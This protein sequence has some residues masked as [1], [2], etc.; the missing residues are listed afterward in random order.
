METTIGY[1]VIFGF[2]ILLTALF[3]FRRDKKR[4]LPISEQAYPQII[5]TVLIKKEKGKI[6][7]IILQL[8]PLKKALQTSGFYLELTNEKH[9]KETL[10]IM[11]LIKI[12]SKNVSLKQSQPTLFTIPFNNFVKFLSDQPDSFDRF[13]FVII[14]A[15]DKKF[16]SH[17][18]ILN[19]RWGLF[20]QDSGKYN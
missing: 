1:I 9:E 11:H 16:K 19:T 2:G 12:P 8:R 20:K 7:E 5:L 3:L 4:M 18:L 17:T 15:E 6:S 14:S 10:D 13:R